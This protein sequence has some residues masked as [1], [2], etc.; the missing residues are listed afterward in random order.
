MKSWSSRTR[1][2][3]RL[4]WS[5]ASPKRASPLTSPRHSR[6]GRGGQGLRVRRRTPGRSAPG[7]DGFALCRRW[8][9]RRHSPHTVSSGA[10]QRSG[11]GAQARCGRRRLPGQPFAFAELLARV[12]AL[13]RRPH[14]GSLR[15]EIESATSWST[16]VA[17]R[18]PRRE[19]VPLTTRD[20]Q[21][22]EFLARQ[23][24]RNRHTDR[25][26]G[27]TCRKA[28]PSRTRTSSTC[29]SPRDRVR[30]SLHGGHRVSLHGERR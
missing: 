8:R 13:L 29:T 21:L 16:R 25:A 24:R 27:A 18:R 15:P 4:F 28:A 12:R 11:T 23:C 6:G 2:R 5:A 7:G 30:R 22:L 1:R 9:E 17:P 10:G 20:Y 19:P 26:L 14:G 3:Q